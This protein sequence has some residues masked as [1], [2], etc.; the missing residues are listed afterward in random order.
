MS[1]NGLAAIL[2]DNDVL[3]EKLKA[4]EARATEM[5]GA[6]DKEYVKGTALIRQRNEAEARADAMTAARDQAL[7]VFEATDAYADKQ[8]ARAATLQAEIK[9]LKEWLNTA[10][11]KH[12]E[13]SELIARQRNTEKAKADAL[14]A[15]RDEWAAEV[16]NLHAQVKGIVEQLAAAEARARGLMGAHNLLIAEQ[17]DHAATRKQLLDAQAETASAME[18]FKLTHEQYVF[19]FERAEALQAEVDDRRRDWVAAEVRADAAERA[20]RVLVE[21]LEAVH[22]DPRFVAVWFSFQNHGGRYTEPTY[23]AELDAAKAAL[24]SPLVGST[25]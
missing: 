17:A 6:Y 12:T 20:L 7:A 16:N 25:K 4:A 15:E 2:H 11:W 1:E 8:K 22:A 24:A 9:Q 5:K 14:Q 19:Q 3:R 10:E 18:R 21:K 13:E 23:T